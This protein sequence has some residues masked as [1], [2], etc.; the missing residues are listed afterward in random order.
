MA[1]DSASVAVSVVVSLS[2]KTDA[3]WA[4]AAEDS[5]M[6]ARPTLAHRPDLR[7]VKEAGF[8]KFTPHE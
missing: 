2:S 8:F 5:A 6:A 1:L 4:D 3:S 7:F